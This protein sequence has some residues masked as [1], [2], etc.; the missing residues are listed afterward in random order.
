MS[1]VCAIAVAVALAWRPIHSADLGYHLAYGDSFW[2]SGRLVDGDD[3]V[4]V[5]PDL[6]RLDSM[7]GNR[8]PGAWIDSAGTYR[9][10]NANYGS[11]IVLSLAY[12]LGGPLALSF[13]KATLVAVLLALVALWARRL[14]GDHTVAAAGVLLVTAAA[15]GRFTVRPEL[16][17]FVPLV[18]VAVLAT[19]PHLS[20]RSVLWLTACHWAAMQLHSYWLLGYCLVGA[21]CLEAWI[22]SRLGRRLE[23]GVAS[24]EHRARVLTFALGAMTAVSFLNPWGW[25]LVALPVQT[26]AFLHA[27]GIPPAPGATSYHPW[28]AISEFLPAFRASQPRLDQKAA[29]G[30]L[31]LGVLA[32]VAAGRRARWVRMAILLWLGVVALSMQRNLAPAALLLVPLSLGLLCEAR[33]ATVADERRRRRGRARDALSWTLVAV[34]AV[35]AVSIV[36]GAFYD[37]EG[38]PDRFG[39]G[40]STWFIPVEAT[41][42]VRDLPRDAAV[43]TTFNA[44]STVLYF[45]RDGATFRELPILTNTWAYPALTTMATNMRLTA[46]RPYN[47]GRPDFT[48]FLRFAVRHDI[49]IAVLDCAPQPSQLAR[50]LLHHGWHWGF[51]DGKHVVLLRPGLLP[52]GGPWTRRSTLALLERVR[53]GESRPAF[54]LNRTAVSLHRLGQPELAEVVWRAAVEEDPDY[55]QAWSFLGRSL[56]GRGRRERSRAL[57]LEA[58]DCLRRA[59]SAGFDDAATGRALRQVDEA[60]RPPAPSS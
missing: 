21:L 49:G 17:G 30:V 42:Y 35:W 3:F 28:G 9:F 59:S 5:D 29:W 60:L 38:R 12:R 22:D 41:R 50:F 39:S 55:G 34:A 54:H 51:F 16:F 52:P 47:A 7:P 10:P 48:P 33:A 56:L 25:R 57:L 11:Q 58:R 19:S 32:L 46:G 45:S 24:P 13:L 2:R 6:A 43:F 20:R 40:L 15:Y 26:L 1:V 14:G 18:G 36:T 37:Q 8:P 27:N 44:S 31:V 4:Y 53:T 23:P